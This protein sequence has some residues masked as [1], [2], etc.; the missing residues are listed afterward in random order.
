MNPSRARR[1]LRSR[2]SFTL[3]GSVIGLSAISAP[4]LAA[5]SHSVAV[6]AS[7]AAQRLAQ[8]PSAPL[9]ACTDLPVLGPVCLPVL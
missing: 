1:S 2:L 8:V 9:P 7:A 6:P 3:M 5:E 4:A